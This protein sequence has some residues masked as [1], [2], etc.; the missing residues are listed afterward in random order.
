MEAPANTNLSH[1]DRKFLR[2][3]GESGL[4]EVTISQDVLSRLTDPRIRDFA[5]M[6]I[7]DHS[8]A[9]TQLTQLATRKGV[10]IPALKPKVEQ[11]WAGKTS[12]VDEDYIKA[13]VKDHDEAVELFE[14]AQKSDDPEIAA[15]AQQTLPTLRHHL[16]MA[17]D[18]KKS[19]K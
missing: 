8:S 11:K 3:A 14:K 10:E 15:F 18:L 4:K 5:Q 9:N 19:T 7:T 2:M 1:S 12:D 17:R 13:M 16:A 6:M